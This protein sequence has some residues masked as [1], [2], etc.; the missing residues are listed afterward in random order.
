LLCSRIKIFANP[1]NYFAESD[2]PIQK[3]KSAP[4]RHWSPNIAACLAEKLP[5]LFNFAR[6]VFSYMQTKA[7]ASKPA[8]N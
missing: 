4:A 3:A 2:I 7:S 1:G 5:L 8:L 6:A